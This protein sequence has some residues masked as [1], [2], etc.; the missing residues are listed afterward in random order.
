[1]S[2]TSKILIHTAL[3]HEAKPLI[4]Y[5]DLVQNK[6]YEPLKLFENE[7]YILVVSGMGRKNTQKTLPFLYEKY[8]IQKAINIGIAGCK[9]RNIK[10]GT[11]CCINHD[12]EQIEHATIT[13]VDKPLADESVLETQLVD[14]EA[15]M[16][17]EISRKHLKENNIFVFK[18][19]SDYLDITIPDKSFVYNSIKK[20]ISKWEIV[21]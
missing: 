20:S 17:L 6:L 5:F 19:I 18:I 11:L 9:D 16:F 14:M 7:K 8:N 12:F 21:I 2:N 15:D 1:M 3:I 4:H 13:T 10:L